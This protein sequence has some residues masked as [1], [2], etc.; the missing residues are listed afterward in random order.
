MDERTIKP[1]MNVMQ[2]VG[3]FKELN[4]KYDPTLVKRVTHVSRVRL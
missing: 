4:L 3:V 2:V 1:S